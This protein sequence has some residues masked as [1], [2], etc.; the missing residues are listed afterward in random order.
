MPLIYVTMSGKSAALYELV[1]EYI[2][3]HIFKLKPAHFMTDFETGLRVAINR[4]YPDAILNGCWF[5][6]SAA[7]RRRM[8]S[9]H[10]H[11]L[12][13]ENVHAKFV[14]RAILSLPLLPSELILEGYSIIKHQAVFYGVYNWFK[15]MFEYFDS[16][17]LALVSWNA[18]F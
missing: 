16:F 4:Y 10:L 2:E 18:S 3:Q 5:H 7:V 8:L 17:W 13:E 6:F 12:I 11:S 9:L 1:F 14:Y 15:P